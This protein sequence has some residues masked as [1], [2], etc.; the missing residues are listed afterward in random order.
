[1]LEFPL[2]LQTALDPSSDKASLCVSV[3]TGHLVFVRDHHVLKYA[4]GRACF[5]FSLAH[6]GETFRDEPR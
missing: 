5:S 6:L 1:M 3:C 4:C 2:V